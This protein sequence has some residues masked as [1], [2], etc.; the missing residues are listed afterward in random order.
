M[1]SRR[2]CSVC[3]TDR[4]ELA[5]VAGLWRAYRLCRPWQ[6]PPA[7]PSASSA[8]LPAP[9]RYD[10]SR[11]PRVSR[12]ASFAAEPDV[13]QPIAMTIDHK[14][15]L[16][17]VENYSYPIWLGGPKRQGPHPDL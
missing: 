2:I 4:M 3:R 11:C 17:V 16:W 6:R 10:G 8:P 9:R 12:S 5:R 7:A 1:Q 15:R 13:V 14:G